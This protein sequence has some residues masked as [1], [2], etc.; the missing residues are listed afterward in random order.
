MSIGPLRLIGRAFGRNGPSID[1]AAHEAT[2]L[3]Q[4]IAKGALTKEE[5][6]GLS[7]A[8]IVMYVAEAYSVGIEV[9]TGARVSGRAYGEFAGNR[10][11]G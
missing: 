10:S 1:A 5:G 6:V 11:G 2:H 8:E 7:V 4:E 3:L 9:A